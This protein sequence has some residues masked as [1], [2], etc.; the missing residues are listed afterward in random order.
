MEEEPARRRTGVDGVG[1]ALELD[2]LLVQMANQIDQLLDA[3]AQ[4]IQLPDHERVTLAQHFESLG[5]AGTRGPR[6][7]HLVLKDLLAASLGQ[8]FAL[9]FQVLILRRD[10]RIT[11]QHGALTEA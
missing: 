1:E 3:A 4:T 10:A 2:A 7:A 11:D 8:G 5:Q 9:K 6:A